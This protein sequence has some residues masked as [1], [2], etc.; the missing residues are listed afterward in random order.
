VNVHY[1]WFLTKMA[2]SYTDLKARSVIIEKKSQLN[3]L[4]KII[5]FSLA[6]ISQALN[7]L[8]YC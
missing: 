3:Y 2:F 6:I 4:D 8:D 5:M 1:A 7:S